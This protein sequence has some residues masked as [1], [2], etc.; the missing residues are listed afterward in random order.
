M[1][2]NLVP[3]MMTFWTKRE[4]LDYIGDVLQAPANTLPASAKPDKVFDNLWVIDCGLNLARTTRYLRT[5]G[6]IV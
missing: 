4:A 1:S 6:S 5:D 2:K 3:A